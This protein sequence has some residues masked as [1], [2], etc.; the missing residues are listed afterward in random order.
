MEIASRNLSEN[1]AEGE[2]TCISYGFLRSRWL[3]PWLVLKKKV[4]T[5]HETKAKCHPFCSLRTHN[6][7]AAEVLA[8]IFKLIPT[9]MLRSIV[10]V[11][12]TKLILSAVLMHLC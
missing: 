1:C 11:A 6:R 12:T 7:L 8:V 10:M 9:S 2:L 5:R 4:K 3:E